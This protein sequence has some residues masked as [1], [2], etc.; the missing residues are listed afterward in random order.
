MFN[1]KRLIHAL[2]KSSRYII[3]LFFASVF[4]PIHW[5][6][7][8]LLF[9]VLII[10]FYEIPLGEYEPEFKRYTSPT[11]FEK[12]QADV[13]QLHEFVNE[14]QSD[15]RIYKFTAKNIRQIVGDIRK[16][17]SKAK[18]SLKALGV[19]EQEL[20]SIVREVHLF[21]A[22]KALEKAQA[23]MRSPD[24]NQYISNYTRDIRTLVEFG[25]LSFV[26]DLGITEIDLLDMERKGKEATVNEDLPYIREANH[27]ISYLVDKIKKLA[28]DIGVELAYFG[29]SQE[30]LAEC[31]YRGFCAEAA[32]F[33][34]KIRV[35][36]SFA[37][38]ITPKIELQKLVVE[39]GISMEDFGIT[40]FEIG[41]IIESFPLSK[42]DSDPRTTRLHDGRD[43]LT[44]ARTE[45]NEKSVAGSLN[46]LV[47][48]IKYS[49]DKDKQPVTLL[50]L[51]TSEE[52]LRELFRKG[53]K[54]E[55]QKVLS[56][57][58]LKAEESKEDVEEK[59]QYL[60]FLLE[61][62][63]S[64]LVAIGSSFEEIQG[65]LNKNWL[66]RAYYSLNSVRRGGD[67]IWSIDN[68]REYAQKAGK[69][70]E[71]FGASEEELSGLCLGEARKLL[72][73]ARNDFVLFDVDYEIEKVNSAIQKANK[74]LSDIETNFIEL[75]LLRFLG[76][77][78]ARIKYRHPLNQLVRYG[79]SRIGGMQSFSISGSGEAIKTEEEIFHGLFE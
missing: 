38:T 66:A 25:G 57:I 67:V 24:L 40:Q 65:L 74:K 21:F 76:K 63:K 2:A 22:K 20:I 48:L 13:E 12:A 29:T 16:H 68:F 9:M 50:E 1:L 17:A 33:V 64:E 36:K 61:L 28:A 4:L 19:S 41:R 44:S 10:F 15:T 52:E 60:Y 56:Q 11:Y 46:Y 54:V 31:Q 73:H 42:P 69:K 43:C 51:G 75:A 23:E 70:I 47:N 37:E 18:V 49:R 26:E 5:P 32:V 35:A 79:M 78:N 6:V 27:N 55:A 62:A 7:F 72:S 14:Y 8:L 59:I 71:D 3:I 58:R 34:E 45:V 53:Y 77:A 30:E 39:S